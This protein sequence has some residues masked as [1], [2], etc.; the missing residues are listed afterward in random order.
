MIKQL[1][2]VDF[3][4]MKKA[5]LMDIIVL[6]ALLC[7]CRDDTAV[8]GILLDRKEYFLEKGDTVTLHANVQPL[9]AT[10]DFVI[11]ES[12][13]NDIATV[14]DDGLVTASDYGKVVIRGVTDD[15]GYADSC[16]VY[17]SKPVWSL[18]GKSGDNTK[19]STGVSLSFKKDFP[20]LSAL[21]INYNICIGGSFLSHKI[22]AESELIMHSS[23]SSPYLTSLASK[24][25]TDASLNKKGSLMRAFF[26]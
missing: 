21:L 13:N 9:N 16:I 19:D 14:D 24:Y 4:M 12:E 15:G 7:S 5:I 18:P 10:N 20:F 11:W 2:P 22:P 1:Y 3:C 8:R 6:L 26:C 25:S 17:I 23:H